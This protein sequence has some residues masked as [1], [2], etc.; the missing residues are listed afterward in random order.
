MPEADE[1]IGRGRGR[2]PY[3]LSDIGRPGKR[4]A[5]RKVLKYFERKTGWR[6]LFVENDVEA[7][8]LVSEDVESGQ[9]K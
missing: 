3:T 9:A 4:T 2:P 8:W 7:I 6:Q 1:D 5:P